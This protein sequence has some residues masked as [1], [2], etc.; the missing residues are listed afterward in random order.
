[1]LL[2]GTRPGTLVALMTDATP[3]RRCDATLVW[4]ALAALLIVA[5]RSRAQSVDDADRV[6]T[7]AVRAAQWKP[8]QEGIVG[9]PWSVSASAGFAWFSGSDA[10]DGQPGFAAELRAAR[11]LSSDN[12]YVAGSY[13][14]VIGQTEVT[15]PNT[16]SRDDQSH[17]LNVPT[18]AL[19]FRTDVTPS[20][21]LFIEPKLGVVFGDADTA[22]VGGASAGAEFDLQPGMS[23][24]VNFTGLATRSSI[25][26]SAGDA[27]LD[28]IWSVGVGLAFEF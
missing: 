6:P 16:G 8:T 1:M 4:C 5:P 25:H 28:A 9:L 18:I 26:T 21:H 17:V 7:G 2:P 11:D 24:R 12:I 10:V 27:D 3:R 13:L 15:N 23:F 22:P 19:G 14:L 20:I